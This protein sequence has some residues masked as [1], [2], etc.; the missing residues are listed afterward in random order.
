MA[1]VFGRAMAGGGGGGGGGEGSRKDP[2]IE[3][4]NFKGRRACRWQ[5]SSCLSPS[6]SFASLASPALVVLVIFLSAAD[7]MPVSVS[8]SSDPPLRMCLRS[9]R[10]EMSGDGSVELAPTSTLRIRGGAEDATNPADLDPLQAVRAARAARAKAQ[11]QQEPSS[12]KK[13]EGKQ[14]MGM[15]GRADRL[16]A[17]AAAKDAKKYDSDSDDS[18]MQ[19]V[20]RKIS[21]TNLEGKTSSGRMPAAKVE[22]DKP[23]AQAAEASAPASGSAAAAPAAAAPAEEAEAEAAKGVATGTETKLS[24]LQSLASSLWL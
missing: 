20:T 22:D 10:A 12:T 17:K 15:K 19:Q 2:R 11:G 21:E 24:S 8:A 13:D 16:G 18:D 9:F 6:S 7:L 5:G 3:S 14:I 23:R 1:R 4:K